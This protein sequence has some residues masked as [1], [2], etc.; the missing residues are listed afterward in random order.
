MEAK[1]LESNLTTEIAIK[2][3][4]SISEITAKYKCLNYELV[5]ALD[6]LL[7]IKQSESIDNS[8]IVLFKKANIHFEELFIE[9]E[10]LSLHGE[11]IYLNIF[12]AVFEESLEKATDFF[13]FTC[14]DF[15]CAKLD[16]FNKLIIKIGVEVSFMLKFVSKLCNTLTTI[17]SRCDFITSNDFD[18]VMNIDELNLIDS[19][20]F[21]LKSRQAMEIPDLKKRIKF[22]YDEIA[23]KELFC[24]GKPEESFE[25][26]LCEN[27]IFNCHQAI[28]ITTKQLNNIAKFKTEDQMEDIKLRENQTYI[29]T[30]VNNTEVESPEPVVSAETTK[31]SAFTTSRQVLAIYY[32]LNEI[33]RRGINQIDKTE[34]AKFIEFL[35][36]K[37]YNNIYKA[38]SNPFKGLDKKNPKNFLN[39]MEY[40]KMHFENLG[41]QSIVQKINS[42]AQQDE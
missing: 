31:N 33:D 26:D 15:W 38:L 21:D 20:D 40:I 37:N 41:L 29:E 9:K 24:V 22:Y 18:Y 19:C 10:E 7:M 23:T 42:D 14:S 3:T 28:Q 12:E 25:T 36:G 13:Q 8:H 4:Y 30:D 11:L 16:E 5:N 27:F 32:L 39:D 6:L 17:A 34:K 35:T 2:Q 1:I